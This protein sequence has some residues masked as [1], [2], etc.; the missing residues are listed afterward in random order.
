MRNLRVAKKPT[1]VRPIIIDVMTGPMVV[2]NSGIGVGQLMVTV[3]SPE[4]PLVS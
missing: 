1:V 3:A 2:G 4:L